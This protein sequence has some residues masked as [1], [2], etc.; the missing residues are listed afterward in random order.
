MLELYDHIS[1]ASLCLVSDTFA[2]LSS[3]LY[4]SATMRIDLGF[5]LFFFNE[6]RSSEPINLAE[7]VCGQTCPFHYRMKL[8]LENSFT[9][10]L[11]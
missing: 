7:M 2:F 9:K 8:V 11:L 4:I 5:F 10:I 6:T 1:I 3:Q